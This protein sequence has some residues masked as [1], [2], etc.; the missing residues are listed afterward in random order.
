MAEK[1]TTVERRIARI[2][3][4]QHGVVT[5]AELVA[6]DISDDEIHDRVAKGMLLREYWGVY[7][8]GHRAPS[9]EA[10]YM[11]AVKACGEGAAL[12]G[13]RLRSFTA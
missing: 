11:A 12:S 3:G 2:A 8:V 7:R 6:A 10:T 9:V 4:R 13:E 1:S 5:R